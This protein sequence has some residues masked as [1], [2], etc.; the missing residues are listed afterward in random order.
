MRSGD[1]AHSI[2]L[3]IKDLH[4][5]HNNIEILNDKTISQSGLPLARTH[6]YIYKLLHNILCAQSFSGSRFPLVVFTLH[7]LSHD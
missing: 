3:G 2:P 7:N 5:L 6:T 1:L 4:P